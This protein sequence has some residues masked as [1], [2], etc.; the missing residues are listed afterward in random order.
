MMRAARLGHVLIASLIASICVAPSANAQTL[1]GEWQ[2]SVTCD[3]LYN[4]A[5]QSPLKITLSPTGGSSYAL[6]ASFLNATATGT[7]YG[8]EVSWS[9]G[10]FFNA[11]TATG[12]V[13][14][15][16][17]SGE[18]SQSIGPTCIWHASKL[19]ENDF[20]T[21]V[22]STSAEQP[23]D[24]MGV[25]CGVRKEML[26]TKL[27][28]ATDEMDEL[29]RLPANC[30]PNRTN[31]ART[32]NGYGESIVIMSRYLSKCNMVEAAKFKK[33]GEWFYT[34]SSELITSCMQ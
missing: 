1:A 26:A 12:S 5:S 15:D 34:A 6:T 32:V 18:Y 27:R 4:E 31:L 11:L 13:N 33:R 29:A 23:T 30:E 20:T 2:G 21:T 28:Q 25:D 24:A 3:G 19:S 10:N 7:V 9:G 16:R 22:A 8:S 17:M 14:N